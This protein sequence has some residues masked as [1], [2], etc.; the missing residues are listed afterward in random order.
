MALNPCVGGILPVFT[1]TSGPLTRWTQPGEHT[2]ILGT[3]NYN[4]LVL[5]MPW[6]W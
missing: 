3:L 1:E 4:L 6:L 5:L 2:S